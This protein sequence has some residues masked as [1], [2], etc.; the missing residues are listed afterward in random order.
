MK[1]FKKKKCFPV[2]AQSWGGVCGMGGTQHNQHPVQSTPCKQEAY[3][4][5]PVTWL[6]LQPKSVQTTGTR[7]T[8]REYTTALN[9]S[10]L[11]FKIPRRV[12]IL[13]DDHALDWQQT[14]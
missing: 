9:V 12:L 1:L 2:S 4:V 7:I 10:P 14:M 3:N 5:W 11:I 13:A 8:D 6:Q